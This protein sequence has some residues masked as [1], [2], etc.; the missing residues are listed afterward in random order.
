MEIKKIKKETGLYYIGYGSKYLETGEV[1]GEIKKDFPEIKLKKYSESKKEALNTMGIN[2]DN[3]LL[4]VFLREYRDE[5]NNIDERKIDD[6]KSMALKVYKYRNGD[7]VVFI[8]NEKVKIRT[9]ELTVLEEVKKR[10]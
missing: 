4:A 6:E 10:V 1:F 7:V 8:D 5:N 9:S 3:E 2:T